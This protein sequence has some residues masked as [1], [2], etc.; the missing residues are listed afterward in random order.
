MDFL[1]DQ[2]Y[3]MVALPK[4]DIAPLQLL[5]QEGA[6]VSSLESSLQE[7]FIADVAPV[8]ATI[9]DTEVPNLQGQKALTM[10]AKTGLNFLGNILK[11][12]NLGGLKTQSDFNDA[13]KIVFSFENVKEDKIKLLALDNFISGSI[14]DEKQFKTYTDRLKNSE[15]FV[16]SAVLKCNA[17]SI[18]VLDQNN[19]KIDIESSLKGI[20]EGKADFERNKDNS[21]KIAHQSEKNLVFAFKA[22]QILYDKTQWFEFWKKE[23]TKFTIKNQEGLVLKS[24]DAFPVKTLE[25]ASELLTIKNGLF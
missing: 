24:E 3:N 19:Q 12:L 6:H 2:G 16:I 14:P 11:S 25:P 5:S 10:G 9:A 1:Q 15:L 4:P 13:D 23:Q 22:V 21:F 20:I 8:P 18:E 17:F 7:L